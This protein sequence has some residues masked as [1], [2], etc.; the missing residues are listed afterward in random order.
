MT[1]RGWRRGLTAVLAFAAA[2]LAVICVLG[3]VAGA[4]GAALAA[5]FQR[6]GDVLH[7]G[8][9]GFICLLGLVLAMGRQPMPR[10]CGGLQKL[11]AR[12]TLKVPLLLGAAVGLLPC[13]FFVAALGLIALEAQGLWHGMAL[14]LAF[15]LGKTLS[16]VLALAVAASVLPERVVRTVAGRAL[17]QRLGGAVLFLL[18]LNLIAAR[19]FGG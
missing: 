12:D 8:G 7:Y 13:W 9:A 2:R 11:C 18:G 15:G 16:P 19:V 5:A 3:G 1:R 10:F 17:F 4:A 14:G 6:Y